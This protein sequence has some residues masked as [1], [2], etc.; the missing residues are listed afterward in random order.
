VLSAN[1]SNIIPVA[2]GCGIM[3]NRL[4]GRRRYND[5]CGLS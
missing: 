1:A 4:K 5:L 2:H 3:E